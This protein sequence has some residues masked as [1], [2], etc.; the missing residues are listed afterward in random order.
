MKVV[1]RAAKCIFTKTKIP[2]ASYVI[3]QYVGC[4]HACVYCYAKFMCRWK[5]YGAWGSWVE[6]KV[7]APTLIKGKYVRGR[8]YKKSLRK[9]A[10]QSGDELGEEGGEAGGKFLSDQKL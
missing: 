8:V 9:P 2:G 7:N 3:N 6:A 1:R 10:F 4:E 5:S